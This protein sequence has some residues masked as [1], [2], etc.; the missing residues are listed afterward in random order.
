MFPHLAQVHLVVP[1]SI[2]QGWQAWYCGRCL[3]RDEGCYLR[4]SNSQALL[5]K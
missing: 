2:L 1:E 4:N 3:I 5:G